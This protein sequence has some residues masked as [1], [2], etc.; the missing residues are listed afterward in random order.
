VNVLTLPVSEVKNLMGYS[1]KQLSK[2]IDSKRIEEI[3]PITVE[4]KFSMHRRIIEC[5][6]VIGLIQGES[7]RMIALSAHYDHLGKREE[8]YYPG[9]DDNASGVAALLELAELF[10]DRTD[11]RHSIQ[12]VAFAAEEE[13]LFGSTHHVNRPDFVKEQVVCNVNM[14]MIARTDEDHADDDPYLYSLGST[15]FESLHPLLQ[16]ADS[17]YNDCYFDYSLNSS[18]GLFFLYEMTDNGNYYE[19]GIP[20]LL[21]ISGTHPDYHRPSDTADKINYKL[22]ENRVRQIALVVELLQQEGVSE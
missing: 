12:F 17:L 18:E 7:D 6:N 14:D 16:R 8:E 11:L 22:L 21:F 19:K 10:A 4:I 9:A 1:R 13:G 2:A 15:I 20:A 3:P 5:Y